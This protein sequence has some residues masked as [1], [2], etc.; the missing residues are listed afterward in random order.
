LLIK[1]YSILVKSG[2]DLRQ[3]QFATQLINEFSQIF[4]IEKVDAWVNTYEIISTGNNIGLIECIPNSVSLDYL[5]RKSKDITS[6]KQFYEKYFG[7]VNSESNLY[8]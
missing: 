3:E 5:K 8:L 4:K 2:E 7:P 6:L 1:F